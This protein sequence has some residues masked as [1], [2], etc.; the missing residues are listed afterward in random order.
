M[1]YGKKVSTYKL[2]MVSMMSAFVFVSNFFSIPIGDVTRVHFG[3]VFCVLSGLLL[4]PVSG[5]LCAGIGSFFFDLFNPLY[6]PEALIT[7]AFK[8][9]IGFFA[10][11]IAHQKGRLGA[12]VPHNIAG[13]LL[14]S[15]CY[16]LLYLGK[17]LVSQIYFL[18]NPPTT[19]W[20]LMATKAAASSANAVIAVVVAVLLAPVFRSAMK[21]A[22][23]Y[24]KL[25]PA[26]DGSEKQA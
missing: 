2:A 24:D 22:G 13:A 23:I 16:V 18:R 11:L 7:F 15:A 4:G 6:A 1:A 21:S 20:P 26:S 9:V 12:S 10:G 3:N 19:Y 5:G 17:N 14:G 8:F 25:F